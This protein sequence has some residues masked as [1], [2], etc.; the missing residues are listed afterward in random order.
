M[1]SLKGRHAPSQYS[2]PMSQ[3]T[4]GTP[5]HTLHVGQQE[6]SSQLLLPVGQMFWQVPLEGSLQVWLGPQQVSP[7]ASWPAGQHVCPSLRQV[8]PT[9]QHVSPQGSAW[10]GQQ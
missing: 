9:S 3:Q 8:P 6:P 5:L 4:P 1:H 2:S 7:Q 10:K